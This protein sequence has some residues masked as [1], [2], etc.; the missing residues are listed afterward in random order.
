[1]SIIIKKYSVKTENVKDNVK[2]TIIHL[3]MTFLIF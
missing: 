2:S 1:M 3:K